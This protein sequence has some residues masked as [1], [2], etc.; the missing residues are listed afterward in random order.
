MDGGAWQAA[1]HGSQRVGHDWA[2][3]QQQQCNEVFLQ[4]F[5]KLL[6]WDFSFSCSNLVLP[7]QASCYRGISFPTLLG[8]WHF[9]ALWFGAS[10]VTSLTISFLAWEENAFSAGWIEMGKWR[11]LRTVAGMMQGVKMAASPELNTEVDNRVVGAHP[12]FLLLSHHAQG[13]LIFL[14]NFI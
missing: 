10:C 13:F 7:L 3:K 2:T 6:S 14:N 8:W 4:V 9:W 1:I 5:L 12:S 11:R